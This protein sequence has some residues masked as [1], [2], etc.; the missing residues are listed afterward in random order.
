MKGPILQYDLKQLSTI[1]VLVINHGTS[2]T[3]M[4]LNRA[5]E[6]GGNENGK[7]RTYSIQRHKFIPYPKLN[8]L[9]F[10]KKIYCKYFVNPRW[11]VEVP[12]KPYI[13]C[14]EINNKLLKYC[15]SEGPIN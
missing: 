10:K 9:F 3:N 13:N 6:G 8:K 5:Q 7:E 11:D 2:D 12:T 15:N 4:E 1:V 14:L